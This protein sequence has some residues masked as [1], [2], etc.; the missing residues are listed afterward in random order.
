MKKTLFLIIAALLLITSCTP[1]ATPV[2]VRNQ[3]VDAPTLPPATEP[4]DAPEEPTAAPTAS[5]DAATEPT[6][7]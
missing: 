2:G 3:T 7:A 5:T 1:G 4:A 6:A